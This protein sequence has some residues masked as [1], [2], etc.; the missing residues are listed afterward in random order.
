MLLSANALSPLGRSRADLD[1]DYVIIS[2]TLHDIIKEA[3]YK[4]TGLRLSYVL[5]LITRGVQ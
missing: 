1:F 2:T 3:S 5:Q 4:L